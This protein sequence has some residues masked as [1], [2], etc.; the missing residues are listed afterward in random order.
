MG[1]GVVEKN[2]R[3]TAGISASVTGDL[4]GG[5]T[6]SIV[7]VAYGLSFA[8]LIFAPPLLPWLGIGIVGTFLTMAVSAAIMS[9]RGTFPFV[10]AGPDGATSAV[11][12]S[13]VA[14][15]VQRLNEMGPPDDLLAPI[16]I[17]MALGTA[18]TGILLCALGFLL[19]LI[20][21]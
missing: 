8:S 1:V 19:S 18:L 15:L 12:A 5:A 4:L 17:T 16:M 3:P 9:T 6:S 2:E 11:T 21:I 7:A 20:H 10:V 13:L 14:A